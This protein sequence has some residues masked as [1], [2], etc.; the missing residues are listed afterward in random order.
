MKAAIMVGWT[1]RSWSFRYMELKG[2]V[3]RFCGES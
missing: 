2:T 3:A 1:L